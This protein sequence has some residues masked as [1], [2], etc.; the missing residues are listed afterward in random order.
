MGKVAKS[1]ARVAT[2]AAS[3]GAEA[4]VRSVGAAR[5]VARIGLFAVSAALL[6]F[7]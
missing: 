1:S 5:N 7:S 3:E 4:V 2:T 6:P